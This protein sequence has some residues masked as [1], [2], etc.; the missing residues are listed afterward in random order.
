ME[1]KK[2]I[3]MLIL[4]V[5]IV[6]AAIILSVSIVAINNITKNSSLT[7][8]RE[9]ITNIEGAI[10][11]YYTFNSELPMLY[12]KKYSIDEISALSSLSLIHI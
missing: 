4:I 7:A 11:E 9:E 10:K 2:G 6:L 12:T 3:T 5:T 1:T 8:F